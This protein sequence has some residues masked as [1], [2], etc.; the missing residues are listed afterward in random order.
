MDENNSPVIFCITIE[1]ET[2]Y[3]RNDDMSLND[4]IQRYSECK[5]PFIELG[6]TSQR[7]D[8]IQFV[9]LEQTLGTTSIEIVP[10]ETELRFTKTR[11]TMS[12]KTS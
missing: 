3:Y 4:L 12:T 6:E 10:D 9:E 8:T 11:V 2:R 1:E 7:I 5:R